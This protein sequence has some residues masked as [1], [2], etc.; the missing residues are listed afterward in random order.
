MDHKSTQESVICHT[1]LLDSPCADLS[2]SGQ[3]RIEWL[4]YRARTCI[5]AAIP[6]G[7]CVLPVFLCGEHDA[8]SPLAPPH[9]FDYPNEEPPARRE[10][11]AAI[12]GRALVQKR[13]FLS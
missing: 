7:S 8:S 9:N 4:A 6:D 11:F 10:L 5:S 12:L 2:L 13:R 1:A 3:F